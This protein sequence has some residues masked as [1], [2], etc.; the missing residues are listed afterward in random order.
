MLPIDKDMLRQVFNYHERTKHRPDRYAASLGYMDWA[1]QPDPFRT[2]AGAEKIALS[3]PNRRAM[4]TY[5]GLFSQSPIA[6]VLDIGLVARLSRSSGCGRSMG[7]AP[8]K[9]RNGFGCF[10]QSM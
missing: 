4:P 9:L 8:A 3:H 2:F 6:A 7:A 5:D 10:A 1:N